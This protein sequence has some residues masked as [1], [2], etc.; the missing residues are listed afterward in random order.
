MSE[1]AAPISLLLERRNKS[2]EGGKE[3]GA[4][5][6][7]RFSSL[8]LLLCS[9]SSSSSNLTATPPTSSH[10]VSIQIKK[11]REISYKLR[12]KEQSPG[13]RGRERVCGVVLFIVAVAVDHGE[14][15]G[16]KIGYGG[17]P[18]EPQRHKTLQPRS[19]PLPSFLVP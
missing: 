12:T 15:L 5:Q 16:K 1:A 8:I 6:I 7:S 9:F 13:E 11:G 19:V 17:S 10:L 18:A 2:Q 4:E 14:L 3:C